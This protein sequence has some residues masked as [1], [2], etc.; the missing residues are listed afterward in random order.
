MVPCVG[1]GNRA[2]YLIKPEEEARKRTVQ[3]DQDIAIGL[4]LVL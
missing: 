4:E 3:Y 2:L 1:K